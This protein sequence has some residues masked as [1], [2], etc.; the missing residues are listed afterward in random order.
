MEDLGEQ[1]GRKLA[2]AVGSDLPSGTAPPADSTPLRR[3]KFLPTHKGGVMLEAKYF[4]ELAV[5]NR[6]GG[7]RFQLK[8]VL[9]LSTVF[10]P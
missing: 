2:C 7:D 8:L 4:H 5:K 1:V 9:P 10:G 6:F 3:L